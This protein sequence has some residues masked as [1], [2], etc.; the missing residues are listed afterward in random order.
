MEKNIAII[1]K[2]MSYKRCFIVIIVRF[3]YLIKIIIVD[4]YKDVWVEIFKFMH[5]NFFY[6]LHLCLL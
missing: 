5:L 2:N 4:F 6:S 1:A 3:A